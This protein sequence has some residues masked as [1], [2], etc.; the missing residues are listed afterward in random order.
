MKSQELSG[1]ILARKMGENIKRYMVAHDEEFL[2]HNQWREIAER[3][4]IK[5][6]GLENTEIKILKV[7][8]RNPN[9]SLTRVAANL[10][11]TPE[12]VRSHFESFLLKNNL[13]EISKRGQNLTEL[14]HE[15]LK[16]LQV[17]K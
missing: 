8:Q 2:T 5:P 13:I 14:G 9:C 1:A 6:L 17:Q 15:Y 3:L 10:E 11:L 16:S 7:L 4:S 12:C